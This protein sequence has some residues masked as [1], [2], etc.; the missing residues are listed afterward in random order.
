VN[1]VYSLKKYIKAEY[2]L[3]PSTTVKYLRLLENANVLGATENAN[4]H[5][6]REFALIDEPFFENL[7]IINI[8][9]FTRGQ[10]LLLQRNV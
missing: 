7:K 9:I 5:N 3:S 10:A 1:S 4:N 6:K 8:R 2:G